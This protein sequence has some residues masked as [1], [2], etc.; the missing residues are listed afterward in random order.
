MS[1]L[2]ALSHIGAMF[3]S[4]I[5]WPISDLFGRKISLMLSGIPA[6]IG[7]LMIAT[8]HLTPFNVDAFYGVLLTGR[9]MTGVY[10]GWS[11]VDVSVSINTEYNLRLNNTA[12]QLAIVFLNV[13]A[14]QS[15]VN[16][17]TW[18]DCSAAFLMVMVC[19]AGATQ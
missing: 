9:I 5:G 8:A 1:S 4:M 15:S 13:M 10:L 17:Y 16:C 11:I 19:A 14:K 3:G 7:W 12:I 6:L 18:Y 2:Q